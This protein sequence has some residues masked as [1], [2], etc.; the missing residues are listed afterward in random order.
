MH[1]KIEITPYLSQKIKIISLL[2]IFM[3]FVQHGSYGLPDTGLHGAF[4][5]IVSLGIADYPVSF[6][7]IVSGYFLSRKFSPTLNWFGNELKKRTSSLLVP[8]LIY[9]GIG[10]WLFDCSSRI[11]ILD[12]LGITS[13]LPAV[14]PLWYV[15]TLILLC[16]LSPIILFVTTLMARHKLWRYLGLFV[17]IAASLIAFPARK[18]LGMSTLYFSFGTF[19]AVYGSCLGNVSTKIK[20]NASLVSL[21]ALLS[22]KLYHIMSHPCDPAEVFL[23][24]QVVP[25]TITSIWYGYDLLFK[26]QVLHMPRWL[27]FASETTFFIYCIE[28]FLR[29][30][31]NIV[32]CKTGCQSHTNT[33]I[34]IIATA[35]L[36]ATLGLLIAKI[37]QKHVPLLYKTL[38]GGR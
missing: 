17:F 29:H 32:I 9:I 26:E 38:A 20:F 3:V 2:A 35:L 36:I 22:F 31:V 5:H 34:W 11:T 23:R 7:F 16:I 18:S 4:K 15:R 12:G 27:Q 19:L 6:F 37:L 24:W 28:S 10:F 21:I 25:F 8:Y 13:L 30:G 1:N 14:G 33:P